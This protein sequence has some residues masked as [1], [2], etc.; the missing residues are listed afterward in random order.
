MTSIEDPERALSLAYAPA[1]KR[2]ALAALWRLD[3]RLEQAL[4][5]SD[6]PIIRCIRLAWWRDAL[7]ALDGMPPAAEPLLRDVAA[8]ILPLGIMGMELAAI[9]EGWAVLADGPPFDATTVECHARLRGRTLFSLAARILSGSTPAFVAKAGEG[10]A[11]ADMIIKGTLHPDAGQIAAKGP[12]ELR[13]VV[14][15]RPLRPLG[16]LSVLARRNLRSP[17]ERRGSPS[18]IV[19]AL[20]HRLSGR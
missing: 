11:L 15:P 1:V 10:W 3:E 9:E 12:A 18:R 2:S 8:H 17:R 14:W 16:M 5:A 19:R 6:E 13:G 7:A 20:W 4:R